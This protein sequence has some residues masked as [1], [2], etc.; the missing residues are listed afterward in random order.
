MIPDWMNSAANQAATAKKKSSIINQSAISIS[1]M[2]E[3]KPRNW[4]QFMNLLNWNEIDDWLMLSF[5]LQTETILAI[6]L[7]VWLISFSISKMKWNEFNSNKSII[8]IARELV[9]DQDWWNQSI[10]HS[11]N[12]VIHQKPNF[13]SL[14]LVSFIPSFQPVLA[15]WFKFIA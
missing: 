11:V 12:S 10:I 5:W 9:S 14:S 13:K 4:L 2:N 15:A 3:M 6:W 8:Q 7:I 1:E